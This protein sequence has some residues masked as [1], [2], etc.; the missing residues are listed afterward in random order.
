MVPFGAA[1][2]EDLSSRQRRLVFLLKRTSLLFKRDRSSFESGL[3]CF[4]DVVP[5]CLVFYAAPYDLFPCH[6]VT[7][8]ATATHPVGAGFLFST[9]AFITETGLDYLR[10]E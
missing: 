6:Q 5:L 4:W 8:G 1:K 9:T 10:Q 3:D 2:K 7:G